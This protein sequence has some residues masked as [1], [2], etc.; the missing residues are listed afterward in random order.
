MTG[1]GLPVVRPPFDA[2]NDIGDEADD[3]APPRVAGVLLAA[4][5]SSRFGDAN[6]LLATVE[7]EP[8]VRRAARTLVDA[9]ADPVVVVVGH[10]ADRVRAAVA[11]LPV[12]TVT[13]D[14]YEAGQSTS[15]RTGIDAI[16]EVKGGE[17]AGEGY[18]KTGAGRDEAEAKV[19]AAVVALGD[20]P[21][22]DPETVETLVAAYAAEAGAALAAAY[23]GARGNPV[24]FD[25]RFFD[26]LAAVDGDVGGREILLTDDASALVA[27]DDPGVRRDVDRPTDLPER[28]DSDDG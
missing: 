15:V 10:E 21:F 7:G 12:K 14:A 27:V 3:A 22:V 24:L 17:E 26:R 8:V 2:G 28:G 9:G 5:T 23:E 16:R 18:E 6:K 20:M 4:G 11:D 25:A 13:N 1:E 19:D